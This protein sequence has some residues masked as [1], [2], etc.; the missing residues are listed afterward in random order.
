MVGE[1]LGHPSMVRNTEGKFI[2]VHR[3][4]IVGP[5]DTIH[6]S[7]SR[8]QIRVSI[9]ILGSNIPRMSPG[10]GIEHNI[11]GAHALAVDSDVEEGLGAEI[12]LIPELEGHTTGRADEE[13][14]HSRTV[15]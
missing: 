2:P 9:V 4:K 11:V 12:S 6:Q 14:K 3:S 8:S 13:S 15:S 5:E 1:D 7:E 10:D